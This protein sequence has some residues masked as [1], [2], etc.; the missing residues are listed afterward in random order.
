MSLLE[1]ICCCEH[2]HRTALTLDDPSQGQTCF[3]TYSHLLHVAGRVRSALAA[4]TAYRSPIAIYGRNCPSVLAAV[5]GVMSLTGET[6]EPGGPPGVGGVACFPLALDEVS[7]DQERSLQQCRVQVV[8]VEESVINVWGNNYAP[9]PNGSIG[10]ACHAL[11]YTQ[12]GSVP[13]HLPILLVKDL[14][15]RLWFCTG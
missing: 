13:G 11:I 6:P 12:K 10:L 4:L 7:A 1:C 5:L 2:R 14:Y 3:H 15:G 8:L 9:R